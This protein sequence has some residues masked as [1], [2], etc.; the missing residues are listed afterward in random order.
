[1]L[2][3]GIDT[4]GVGELIVTNKFA[5]PEQILCESG[6]KLIRGAGFTLTVTLNES[7][8]HD[9]GAEVEIGNTV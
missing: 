7:P 4:L 3:H 8:G 2:C 6:I 1:M 9:F 5:L